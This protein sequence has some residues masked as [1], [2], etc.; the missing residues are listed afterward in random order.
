MTKDLKL[1]WE[2]KRDRWNGYEAE[3]YKEVIKEH[4]EYEEIR[5]LKKIEEEADDVDK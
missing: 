2:S 1:D 5:K 3:M 4:A